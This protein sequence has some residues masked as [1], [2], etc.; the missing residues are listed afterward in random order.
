MKNLFLIFAT[1]GSTIVASKS[2]ENRYD[3]FVVYR[4]DIPDQASANVINNDLTEYVDIWAEPRVGLN[5]DI[6]VSPTDLNLVKAKLKG[7]NLKYSVMV[8]NVQKLIELEQVPANKGA[9][10]STDHPMDW[11]SYHSQED[12]EVY[13]DYLVEKYPDL[14]STEVIG[15]S[16]EGRTMRVL[17]ICKGGKC[18]QKPAMWIDGGIHSREW[19]SSS[20][21]TYIMNELV[22]NGD[23]YPSEIVE[24]LD[25]YI[26]PVLNPDGYE[27]SRTGDRMWRKSR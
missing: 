2:L 17:R 7:A 15:K 13:M 5:S 21:A 23:K 12:M 16:Y 27:Y 9:R 18:G 26:L 8:E 6:M 19:V 11:T 20:T 25:W 4:V 14:V 3:N 22:E 24:Q 1:F 10:I